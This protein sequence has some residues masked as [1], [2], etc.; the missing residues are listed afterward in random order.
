MCKAFKPLGRPRADARLRAMLRC[1]RHPPRQ[2][3]CLRGEHTRERIVADEAKD[4]GFENKLM[5]AELKRLV[6]SCPK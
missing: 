2:A 4:F 6:Y 3:D 5:F 1:G